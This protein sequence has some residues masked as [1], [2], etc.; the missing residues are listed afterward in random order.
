[1]KRK[2]KKMSGGATKIYNAI[3]VQ[4]NNNRKDK[5]YGKWHGSYYTL[6]YMTGLSYDHIGTWVK[7]L[8]DLRLIKHHMFRKKEGNNWV[9]MH[10]FE[11]LS[12]GDEPP[13]EAINKLLKKTVLL[14]RDKSTDVVIE[15]YSNLIQQGLEYIPGS[16]KEYDQFS[17]VAK[18]CK[19]YADSP[20]HEAWSGGYDTRPSF[21]EVVRNYIESCI[22]FAEKLPDKTVMSHHL[23]GPKFRSYFMQNADE[24]EKA[25]LLIAFE[26]GK[27]K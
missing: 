7:E 1:M 16:Q 21:R 8:V 4:V 19:Q 15:I 18:W 26:M 11:I 27:K 12:Y 23:I 25:A 20:H 10:S 13:K 2:L 9:T 17:T 3:L 22:E 5:F 24:G 6:S 14:R